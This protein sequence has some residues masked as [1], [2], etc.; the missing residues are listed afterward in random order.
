MKQVI[1]S[2]FRDLLVNFVPQF[3]G[4]SFDNFAALVMGWVLC[5]GRHT[6]SRVIQFGC[7]GMAQ[8]RKH[9]SAVYRF[10]S[11]A[12]WV[13]DQMEVVVLK[14]VLSFILGTE[15]YVLIDDTLCRKSGP[16]LWGAGMH[17]D[18][19][20]STYGRGSRRVVSFAFGHNFVILSLWVA[21]PWNPNRGI[22]VPVGVRLYRSK[23]LCPAEDYQKRTT[24]ARQ[25]LLSLVSHLPSDRRL[26]VVADAE[27]ACGTVVRDLPHRVVFIGPMAMNA[28]V[29][30]LPSRRTGRGRPAIKGQRLPSPQQL[31]Q[32]SSL[33]WQSRTVHLYGRDVNVLFKAQKCLWYQVAKTCLLHMIVTRDPKGRIEDRAYFTTDPD[34]SIEDIARGFARRWPQEVLHRNVKQ[35]LGLEHPQNGWWKRRRRPKSEK[36]L[37]GPQPHPTRGELAAR[38][39]VPFVLLAYT[40]VVLWYLKH[41]NPKMDV[42]RVRRHAPWYRHK[43]EPSFADMLH[44]ARKA[45]WAP[46]ISTSPS[47]TCLSRNST[48]QLME[49][50]LSS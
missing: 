36:K 4:P 19:L 38:R 2:G 13:L 39:T 31:A 25:M 10:F 14:L 23:K 46:R 7:I 8:A 50:V 47:Q 44:A 30:A 15:V 22:A 21:L 32:N 6:I 43:T 37:P 18:P 41:G 49:L 12:V 1:P 48:N 34:L 11:R 35:H 28:A 26:I 33:R 24:L 3:T 27:Y 16:H 9:H 5:V 45:L 17:H 29:H 42:A 40:I 20:N